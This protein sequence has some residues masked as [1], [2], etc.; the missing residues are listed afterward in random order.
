MDGRGLISSTASMDRIA[1]TPGTLSDGTYISK[2]SYIL[3]TTELR[4]DPTV[5]PDPYTFQADRFMEL[6]ETI[7]P[8]KWQYVTTSMEHQGFG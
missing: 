3:I 2:D 8:N 6:R 1:Q 5:F 4:F 7:N